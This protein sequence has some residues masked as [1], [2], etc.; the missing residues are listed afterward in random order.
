M[1]R[2]CRRY[3]V[4]RSGYYAWRRRP[5]SAHAEQDR[6]L[7]T[8]IRRIFQAH[9][10]R[11][12]S[13]RVHRALT[14]AGVQVSRRR[15]AR[16]MRAAGLRAKAVRG[17]R[18]KA[19]VHR[20]YARQ[21]NRLRGLRVSGPNQVWVGDITYLPVAG[22]WWYLAVV[23]DQYS[24]RVLAWSLTPRRDATVTCAV[25]RAAAR[26]RRAQGVIFHSDRGSEYL[27]APFHA[28]VRALGLLQSASTRGPGDNAHM[29]S[30]FH[31]LKA[32]LTRGVQFRSARVLRRELRRYIRYYNQVRMH[33]ALAY[34]SPIAFEAR[35]A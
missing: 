7:L 22:R 13:P 27:A 12:G 15:V 3:G 14:T 4:T 5:S 10:G 8:Q 17:Y 29:E 1:T 6:Q 16:L 24:R 26:A 34:H 30:F 32:E 25:L 33:S 11:Y 21:P 35:A 19:G 18:A 20:F 23:M 2:L 31:S 28:C 9:A